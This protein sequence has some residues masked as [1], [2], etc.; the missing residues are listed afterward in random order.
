MDDYGALRDKEK[1]DMKEEIRDLRHEIESARDAARG[2][3][4]LRLE[5][6]RERDDLRAEVERWVKEVAHLKL[7]AEKAERDDDSSVLLPP[8][9]GYVRVRWDDND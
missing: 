4:A 3:S 9:F 7:A 8:V 2:E 5:A 6:E 1:A